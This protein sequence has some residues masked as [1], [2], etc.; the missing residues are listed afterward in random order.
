VR[1][2]KEKLPAALPALRSLLLSVPPEVCKDAAPEDTARWARAINEE[3][4]P[5]LAAAAAAEPD[6]LVTGDAHFLSSPGIAKKSGLRIL[7]PAQFL[8][9]LEKE[10]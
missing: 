2:I 6:Y 1:T 9:L 8:L 4:A 5:I 7:T 10:D 3:D